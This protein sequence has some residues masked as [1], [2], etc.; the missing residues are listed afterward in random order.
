MG[1]STGKEFNEYFQL[2]KIVTFKYN[3]DSS[4]AAL[5]LVFDKSMADDRKDWLGLFDKTA[6]LDTSQAEISF[7]EFVD[8]EY[9]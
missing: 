5:D 4:T 7:E 6:A 8:K 9:V 3:K 1:T 2:K